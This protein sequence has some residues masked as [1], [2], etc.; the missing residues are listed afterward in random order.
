[1]PALDG[2]RAVAILMVVLTHVT[3]GRQ[4]ALSIVY[5]T[6]NWPTSFA[7]PSWLEKIGNAGDLGVQLFFVVSAFTLTVRA[8][9]SNEDL[10]GYALRRIF[11]VGPG[12]WLA[13]IAYTL[14]AGFAPRLWAPDGISPTDIA[15]AAAFGSAWQGG[16]SFAV[17]PGGWS[18]SAEVAFYFAL[19]VI[20]RMI[21]GRIWRAVALTCLAMVGAE[22]WAFYLA[23]H[24]AW[25][26]F[27]YR[28]PLVQAPV[29]LCGVTAALAA[30][31][32]KM[33][34]W[35]NM[36]LLL[37]SFAI[38][39]LPVLHVQGLLQHLPFALLAAGAAA[40]SATHP[41]RVLASTALG[42][43]GEVSYS[44]YLVQFA[45]LY[46]SLRM[47]EFLFPSANWVTMLVHYAFTASASFGLACLTFKFVEQPPIRWAA[48]QCRRRTLV[49]LTRMAT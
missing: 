39:L 23:L 5:D 1:M 42:R 24:H 45:C 28:N 26:F 15:V 36:A 32:F 12:Y 38:L 33:P 18:I 30:M 6:T 9:R 14:L 11:R 43:V 8:S 47:A 10:K 22:L 46:G 31:R 40:L 2:L 29:F 25:D 16:A 20:I 27:A 48:A 19:P 7:L 37:L 44:M 35:P 34:N 41:S 13:G 21:N 3:R 17:V 4:A 49:Q